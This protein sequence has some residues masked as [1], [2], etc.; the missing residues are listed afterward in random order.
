MNIDNERIKKFLGDME[1]KINWQK[2]NGCKL[3]DC[4]TIDNNIQ[5]RRENFKLRQELET[6]KKIAEKLAEELSNYK[7]E[8]IICMKTD[9]EHIEIQNGGKCI[10]DK[11]CIIEWARKEVEKDGN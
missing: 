9:C 4:K 5:L 8:E 11:E 2:E 10:G 7:F 6:Y 3:L 1:E